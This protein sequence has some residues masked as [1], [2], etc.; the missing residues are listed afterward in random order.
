MTNEELQEK[1]L[2]YSFYLKK[3]LMEKGIS[4][5]ISLIWAMTWIII[6]HTIYLCAIVIAG[7][8]TQANIIISLFAKIRIIIPFTFGVA[9]IAYG[10]FANHTKNKTVKHLHKPIKERELQQDPERTSSMLTDEGK[11]NPEDK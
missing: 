9:G 4:G 11:T 5:I 3:M 10:L 6:I 7:K 2:M 8:N 1:K